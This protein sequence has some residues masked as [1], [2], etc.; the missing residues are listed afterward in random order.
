MGSKKVLSIVLA[1]LSVLSCSA[2][3]SNTR[4][5]SVGKMR[6]SL[7]S[8]S[9]SKRKSSRR[10]NRAPNSLNS[11]K[12]KKLIN[13]G[14]LKESKNAE[15]AVLNELSKNGVDVKKL[16]PQHVAF[17]VFLVVFC[18][19]GISTVVWAIKRGMNN[20]EPHDP[21]VVDLGKQTDQEAEANSDMIMNNLEMVEKAREHVLVKRF[22]INA[23]ENDNKF[24][25]GDND[26]MFVF[27]IGKNSEGGNNDLVFCGK[28]DFLKS[29]CNKHLVIYKFGRR[30]EELDCA[31]VYHDKNG[32][33]KQ[34]DKVVGSEIEFRGLDK[35]SKLL[36]EQ[37]VDYYFNNIQK[38]NGE[39]MHEIMTIKTLLCDKIKSAMKGVKI[40][41]FYKI[42]RRRVKSK[43]GMNGF[44]FLDLDD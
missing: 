21:N 22:L 38:G 12:S 18:G 20:N 25:A 19:V 32:N 4:S 40:T 33:K 36:V 29:V 26:G 7:G 9:A 14:S 41:K 34:V 11:R 44:G 17:I 28:F 1:S 43:L 37:I 8:W 3:P 39:T 31:P 5:K 15:K 13:S 42:V 2:K 27:S 16:K 10:I 23:V 24:K 30:I 6:N 35:L